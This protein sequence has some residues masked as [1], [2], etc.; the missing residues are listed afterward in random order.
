MTY[1]YKL[2]MVVMI[3]IGLSG[4]VTQMTKEE[5]ATAKFEKLP[6]S[7]KTDI[8]KVI[9]SKL[10][11]PDS[12]K[13]IFHDPKKGYQSSNKQVA[14]IVPVEVNAKNSYGGYTGYTLYYI[15]YLSGQY[16]DV[17]TGVLYEVIK[18]TD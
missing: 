1:I 5:I 15:A 4:C 12:G 17:T 13:Y 9:S 14:M 10:K 8:E 16:Q 18:F 6:D 3:S 11:D 2:L 7:Y